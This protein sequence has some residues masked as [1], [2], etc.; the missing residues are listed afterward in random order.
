VAF[1]DK[2]ATVQDKK[3]GKTA[4][5]C[6]KGDDGIFYL[7][8]ERQVNQP[9]N[10]VL[11]VATNVNGEWKDV[12]EHINEQGKTINKEKLAKP[13]KMCMNMAHR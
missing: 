8:G 4:F 7:R 3:T 5:V 9:G 1:D 10:Q 11:F 2:K 6:E 12:T 13:K